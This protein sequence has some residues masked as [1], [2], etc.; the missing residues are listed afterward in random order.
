MTPTC[1]P[2]STSDA[3]VSRSVAALN[4]PPI[5]LA[6]TSA[7]RSELVEGQGDGSVSSGFVEQGEGVVEDL[8]PGGRAHRRVE[9][10]GK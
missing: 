3:C 10:E 2:H 1:E 4:A 9:A 6:P 5:P 7:T 8:A